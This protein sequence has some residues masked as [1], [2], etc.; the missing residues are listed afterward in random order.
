M[1]GKTIAILGIGRSGV[2]VA[3]AAL[4]AGAKPMVFDEKPLSA[5]GRQETADK[6]KALGVPV[7]T[8]WDGA[9]LD[10]GADLIVTS[11]GVPMRHPKL[12]RAVEEGLEVISEVEFAS[13]I[14]KAPIVAITGTN[15]KSTTTVMTW[16]CLKAAGTDAVLCGNIAGSGYSEIPLTDAASQS[17]PDQILVA[18][19]SSFHLEFI[20][21]FRPI[22]ATI[23]T[24][25]EDHLNRYKGFEEYA[26]MKR[27]IFR[28]MGQGCTAVWNVDD[29]LTK[30]PENEGLS[31][32]V[33][34]GE[35][36]S[37]LPDRTNLTDRSDLS[38]PPSLAH[39]SPDALHILGRDLPKKDLPWS[40]P[41]NHRNAMCAALLAAAALESRSVASGRSDRLGR[42]EESHPSYSA[43]LSGLL[44]FRP[45]EHRLERLGERQGVTVINNSMCTNPA[46]L[47][48]SSQ[49][50]GGV[51]RLLVGGENKQLGFEPVREYLETTSH[52]VYLFGRDALV[53]NEQ[54]GARWR[55]YETMADAFRAAVQEA[56]PGDT[57]MLAPGVAST[58]QFADFRD[59]G[60]QFRELTREWLQSRDGGT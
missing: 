14:G 6:L 8:G 42:S 37:N 51:Q 28:N 13:R 26:E 48:A 9:F 39:E 53:I 55:V 15:G 16:L 30:P 57:V 32:W 18:E 2:S 10:T 41:H 4:K 40:E 22:A 52:V 43:L 35:G 56:N 20:K 27:R 21:D 31:V 44:D 19:I 1:T 38:D 25:S 47:V 54:L 34:S 7:E 23:T 24:L 33:Y 17:T 11:P 49:S 59:R 3:K 5:S 12:L 60:E 45:L 46:A 58:D 50:V 36:R 29:P